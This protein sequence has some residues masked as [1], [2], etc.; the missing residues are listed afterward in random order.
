MDQKILGKKLKYLRNKYSLS[1]DKL[2]NELNEE[3]GSNISKSM[4]SSWENGRYLISPKNLNL[5]YLYF[6]VPPFYFSVDTFSPEDYD[7]LKSGDEEQYM[8]KILGYRFEDYDDYLDT[9]FDDKNKDQDSKEMIKDDIDFLMSKFN[10]S[11]Y[12]K[13]LEYVKDISKINKYLDSEYQK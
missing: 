10:I 5:Y 2:A 6:K 11:G 3:Y 7:S 4:I 9:Y 1:M 13:I 8:D 12:K